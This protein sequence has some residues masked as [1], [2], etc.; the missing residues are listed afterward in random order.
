MLCGVA[1]CASAITRC[2]RCPNAST[3]RSPASRLIDV[4]QRKTAA[5]LRLLL[6]EGTLHQAL[7]AREAQ[8]VRRQPD[9]PAD[10]IEIT[11]EMINAGLEEF[12]GFDPDSD[13]S[14]KFVKAIYLAMARNAQPSPPPPRATAGPR[15]IRAARH[16]VE[17]VQNCAGGPSAPCAAANVRRLERDAGEGGFWSRVLP[18]GSRASSRCR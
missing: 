5:V 15:R 10:E 16:G 9:R 4:R 6:G 3:I 8:S 13:S 12:L 14:I 17:R 7:Y 11:E 18:D 2:V 1:S